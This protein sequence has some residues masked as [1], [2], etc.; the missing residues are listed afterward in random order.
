MKREK[1]FE[2]PLISEVK[3][4]NRFVQKRDGRDSQIT[5]YSCNTVPD[6]LN[7]IRVKCE[8]CSNDMTE[9]EDD[10]FLYV[11]MTDRRMSFVSEY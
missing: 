8:I 11:Y 2:G 10:A 5:G 6:E 1:R 7:F 3:K 9:R 4:V